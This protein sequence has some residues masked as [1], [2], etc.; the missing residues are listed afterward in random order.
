[1]SGTT[2]KTIKLL[3]FGG[4]GCAACKA[5]DRAQVLERL[6]GLYPQIEVVKYDVNDESGETPEGSELAKNYD[7]SDEYEVEM[8]PTMIFEDA[9]TGDELHRIEGAQ[10][11]KSLEQATREAIEELVGRSAERTRS[12][13]ARAAKASL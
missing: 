1:M 6:A 5:M 8:L 10:N 13:K 3:K 7:L 9:E 12:K 4:L 2:G 11:Y